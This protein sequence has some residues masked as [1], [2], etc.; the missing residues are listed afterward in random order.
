ML[1]D[2]WHAPAAYATGL[3]ITL[4]LAAWLTPR[5]WW[6]R[7]NAVA[8]LILCG[9]SWAFG[10][11]LLQYLSSQHQPALAD[12]VATPATAA[13]SQQTA[14]AIARQATLATART[15]ATPPQAPAASA[16]SAFAG[17]SFVTHRDLNL[18]SGAGVQAP[19]LLTVPAG[20]SV[21]PTGLRQGDWW[22]VRASVAGA[23]TTGWA[24]SLWLR[25]DKE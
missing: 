22:Q 2:S 4:F 23:Q 14:F 24:S 11:L 19:R 18:R 10:S 5:S 8:L 20:A 17:H 7:P 1:P 12:A 25:Q 16:I 6:K 13:G 3:V 21:T 9:G 15:T